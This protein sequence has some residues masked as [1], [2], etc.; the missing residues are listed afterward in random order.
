MSVRVKLA[1]REDNSVEPS[2]ADATGPPRLVRLVPIV[3]QNSKVAAVKIFG[4]NLKAKRSM[5]RTASV[6]LPKSPMNLA[7]AMRSLG[8]LHEER[9]SGPQNF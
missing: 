3:L 9:A 4:E 5:I 8:S 1:S 6:A 7:Q 2:R